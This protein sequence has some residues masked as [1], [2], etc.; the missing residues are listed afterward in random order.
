MSNDSRKVRMPFKTWIKPESFTNKPLDSLCS[1]GHSSL[2]YRVIR[3]ILRSVP[4]DVHTPVRH[5]VTY[6]QPLRPSWCHSSCV[7]FTACLYKV[8]NLYRCVVKKHWPVVTP[9]SPSAPQPWWEELLQLLRWAGEHTSAQDLNSQP[10]D[11]TD[12]RSDGRTRREWWRSTRITNT[13]RHTHRNALTLNHQ[14]EA[15]WQSK[16]TTLYTTQRSPSVFAQE[17]KN[18]SE[19]RKQTRP[20]WP[21]PPR[22]LLCWPDVEASVWHDISGPNTSKPMHSICCFQCIFMMMMMM[23]VI[24]NIFWFLFWFHYFGVSMKLWGRI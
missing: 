4:L 8:N 10:A 13:L 3:S 7:R 9:A 5:F 20:L 24:L 21:R 17:N 2:V 14:L 23:M 1:C 19:A 12:G 22:L 6:F 18:H 16:N 11:W 15:Q